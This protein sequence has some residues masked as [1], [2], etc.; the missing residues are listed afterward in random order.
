[1]L[2][3]KDIEAL[4]SLGLTTLQAK[5]YLTLTKIEEASII[6]ISKTTNI[7]RQEIYRV[8]N[9]LHNRCLVEK[10]LATPVR[11]RAIPI[12][13]AIPHL[14]I[15]VNEERIAS[16]N[17]VIQLMERHRHKKPRLKLVENEKQFVLI[18]EKNSLSRRI[19]KAIQNSQKNIKI[20][21]PS[22]KFLP[23]LFDLSASLKDAMQRDVPVKWVIN[24]RLDPN[25]NPAILEHLSKFKH[26]KLKYVPEV[27]L[28]TLGD[29][30]CIRRKYC[31]CCF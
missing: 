8:I 7:A 23:A 15:S 21:M 19:K 9:E 1:L 2:Q 20:V 22:K 31:N 6:T 11:Y 3:K 12:P 10:V 29:S 26:F 28:L 16:H 17:K 27:A 13:E 30:W 14:L 5:I 24:K 18:P 4:A 25:G